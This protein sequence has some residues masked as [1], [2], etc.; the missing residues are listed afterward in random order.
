MGH[1]DVFFLHRHGRCEG[2]WDSA[3]RYCLL[4]A[5]Q[6]MHP[7]ETLHAVGIAEW[8]MQA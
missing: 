8:W 3:H 4:F 7:A 2:K 6:T 5:T 1:K